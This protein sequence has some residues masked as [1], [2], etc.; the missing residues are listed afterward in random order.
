MEKSSITRDFP[1]AKAAY[2]LLKD[3]S[4]SFC[5]PGW[6]KGRIIC[7]KAQLKRAFSNPA[8]S[9]KDSEIDN[10]VSL[11]NSPFPFSGTKPSL[12]DLKQHSSSNATDFSYKSNTELMASG[13]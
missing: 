11:S 10:I 12:N 7:Q 5:Y 1:V 4:S 9:S 2:S 3:V 6:N 8:Q 13:V